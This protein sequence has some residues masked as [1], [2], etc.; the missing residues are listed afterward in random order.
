MPA[1]AA[2][3]LEAVVKEKPLFSPSA[4]LIAFAAEWLHIIIPKATASVWSKSA[5]LK[6]VGR[7]HIVSPEVEAEFTAADLAL[8]DNHESPTRAGAV[9]VARRAF[10]AYDIKFKH[11][12]PSK[13][14]IAGWL[15]KY[16]LELG[17]QKNTTNGM[18]RWASRCKIDW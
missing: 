8:D 2:R 16:G 3:D 18:I 12:A 11:G 5:S 17:R 4:G 1:N 13:D 7:P 9:E 15:A 10:A 14:W 6:R